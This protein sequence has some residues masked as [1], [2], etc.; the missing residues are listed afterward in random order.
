MFKQLGCVTSIYDSRYQNA[1]SGAMPEC[2][3]FGSNELP[4]RELI[5]NEGKIDSTY[6]GMIEL[7]QVQ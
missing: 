2:D 1:S 7:M 3:P 6:P 4:L 5:R